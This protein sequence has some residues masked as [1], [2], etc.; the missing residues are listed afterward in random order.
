[1]RTLTITRRKTSYNS[2]YSLKVYLEDPAGNL[3][4]DGVAC[5]LLGKIKNGATES[6]EVDEHE[7]RVFVIYSKSSRNYCFDSYTLPAG[8]ENVILSGASAYTPSNSYAFRFDGMVDEMTLESRKHGKKRGIVVLILAVVVGLV[9]GI[10]RGF[11]SA[12][13]DPTKG[14]PQTFEVGDMNIVLT[15]IF[16]EA[17]SNDIANSDIDARFDAD[18]I[19]VDVMRERYT[20]VPELKGCTLVQYA[21]LIK[22]ANEIDNS[23]AIKQETGLT[24]LE[25][26]G[27]DD[28]ERD[29]H[30]LVSFYQTNDAFW[31]VWFISFTEDLE[32]QRPVILEWAKSVTFD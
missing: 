15:D 18:S 17:N 31:A 4:I 8:N 11:L 13:P 2:F 26:D 6:F 20:T 25:F 29:V 27:T 24:F 19:L 16:D 22:T 12:S 32:D 7:R 23:V 14:N 30:Y 9:I 21:E 28:L 1:M 10:V 5:T 3:V